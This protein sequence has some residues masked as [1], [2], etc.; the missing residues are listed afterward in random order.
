MAKVG[1]ARRAFKADGVPGGESFRAT[2]AFAEAGVRRLRGGE[3]AACGGTDFARR[4]FRNGMGIPA[5][6]R[7]PQEVRRGGIV[8]RWTETR[9]AAGGLLNRACGAA[10]ERWASIRSWRLMR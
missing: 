9:V 3:A 4:R 2:A 7:H 10:E 1:D 8:E 5:E 6:A